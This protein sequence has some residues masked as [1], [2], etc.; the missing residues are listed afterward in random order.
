PRDRFSGRACAWILASGSPSPEIRPA[1]PDSLCQQTSA[2]PVKLLRERAAEQDLAEPPNRPVKRERP[3]W[4]AA[5][6]MDG[7]GGAED[8]RLLGAGVHESL[9]ARPFRRIGVRAAEGRALAVGESA[10]QGIAQGQP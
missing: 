9:D 2:Q 1:P 7:G 10:L 4:R 8:T 6:P 5:Q 3:V